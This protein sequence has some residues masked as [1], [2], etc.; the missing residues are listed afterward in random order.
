MLSDGVSHRRTTCW[1]ENGIRSE[2]ADV[3]GRVGAVRRPK[4]SDYRML[5][6]ICKD[7]GF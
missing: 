1:C 6:V 7:R 2:T 4:S 5:G 3:R